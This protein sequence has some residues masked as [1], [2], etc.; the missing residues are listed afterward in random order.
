MSI[1]PIRQPDG[2]LG[3]PSGQEGHVVSDQDQRVED[4]AQRSFTPTD[5]FSEELSSEFDEVD[6]N[7]VDFFPREYNVPDDF[8]LSSTDDE[9]SSDFDSQGNYEEE[10]F[11]TWLTEQNKDFNSLSFEEHVKLRENFNIEQRRPPEAAAAAETKV[12]Q[13]QKTEQKFQSWLE[14]KGH[15]DIRSIPHGRLVKL[16]EDFNIEQRRPPGAAAAAETKEV[17]NEQKFQSWLQSQGYR[18]IRTLPPKEASRLYEQFNIE[19]RQQAAAA[20]AAASDTTKVA[21]GF[22]SRFFGKS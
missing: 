19:Q 17:S 8:D 14:S 11:K 16:R 1:N 10:S 2:G 15:R 7:E 22:F 21:K 6:S 3:L 13:Q 4:V 20:T 5:D 12:S 18:S 9:L